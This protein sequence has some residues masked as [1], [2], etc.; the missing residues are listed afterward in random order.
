MKAIKQKTDV[1]LVTPAMA[2]SWLEKNTE[3]RPVRQSVVSN[4]HQLYQRG[5]W[6]LTHQGVA[7]DLNG[8]LKD[9]QHR[10]IFISQLPDSA[11][12]PIAV[13]TGMDVD[14]FGVID[15][16]ARRTPSDEL[17]INTQLSAAANFV[18]KI[19]NNNQQIALTLPYLSKFV[20]FCHPYH[21]EL[22]AYCSTVAKIWSSAPVRSA[23]IVQMA[24]GHNKEF[25]MSVY[26]SL[27]FADFNVMTPT[28]QALFRQQMN[29]KASGARSFDLFCR[30]LRVFDSMAPSANKIQISSVTDVTKNVRE[31]LFTQIDAPRLVKNDPRKGGSN[32]AKPSTNFNK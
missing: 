18:A 20:E 17:G 22:T 7:F 12:V 30:S 23:A 29:G 2:R 26:R 11:Q 13:T 25:V 27:V 9:G 16:G 21:D 24:R 1:V 6:K 15:V 28:A 3:N 5:E 14:T 8:T 4:F 32:G 31:F 10:L 19:F